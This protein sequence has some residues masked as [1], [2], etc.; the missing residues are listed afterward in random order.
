MTA[1]EVLRD[2][3]PI[4]TNDAVRK[5]REQSIPVTPDGVGVLRR[6]FRDFVRVLLFEG[7]GIERRAP[8][9]E[10]RQRGTRE[11]SGSE[12]IAL[13]A[14]AAYEHLEPVAQGI[15]DTHNARAAEVAA[16][17]AAANPERERGKAVERAKREARDAARAE[18]A[19]RAHA[20]A[21]VVPLTRAEIEAWPISAVD[22]ERVAALMGVS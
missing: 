7:S 22:R 8:Y 13:M 10:G 17:I 5:C 11:E 21:V 15:I 18:E 12:T 1:L 4:S 20:A 16:R 19:A 14:Q 2:N 9:V 3:W 6:K